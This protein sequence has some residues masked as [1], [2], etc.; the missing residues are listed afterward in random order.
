MTERFAEA[1]GTKLILVPAAEAPED[2]AHVVAARVEDAENP[3]A[4]AR[5]GE[6]VRA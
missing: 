4:G 2:F 5:E 3:R 1:G 6:P